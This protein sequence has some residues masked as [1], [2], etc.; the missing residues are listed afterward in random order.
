FYE[1]NG[2]RSDLE[3]YLVS[4]KDREWNLRRAGLIVG[5]EL[6]ESMLRMDQEC[7]GYERHRVIKELAKRGSVL[8]PGGCDGFAI[9]REDPVEPSVGPVISDDRGAGHELLFASLLFAGP[10][11]KAVVLEEGIGHINY[12]EK[13]R[14][15]YLGAPLKI[16]RSRAVAFAGLELG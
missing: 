12:E 4:L 13:I 11:T 6:E 5:A 2:F 1:A 3:G 7:F 9:V 10:N 14:R 8:K 15:L 16:D